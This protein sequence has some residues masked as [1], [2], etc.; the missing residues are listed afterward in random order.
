MSFGAEGERMMD[1]P[2][3]EC[4]RYL[5]TRGFTPIEFSQCSQAVLAQIRGR[6]GPCT[7][8][9]YLDILKEALG[10]TGESEDRRHG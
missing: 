7:D 1:W 10:A 9:E 4:V 8:G 2:I 3:M 6:R 5:L